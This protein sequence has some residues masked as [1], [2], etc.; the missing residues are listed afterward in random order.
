MACLVD[1]IRVEFD[2]T[3]VDCAINELKLLRDELK[4][5]YTRHVQARGG[6]CSCRVQKI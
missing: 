2:T 5:F 6:R 3:G 1:T 4:S